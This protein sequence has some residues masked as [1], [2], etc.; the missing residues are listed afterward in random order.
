MQNKEDITYRRFAFPHIF[1]GWYIVA[2]GMGMHL[3]TSI[4]WVYGMQVF[5]TPIVQT[6]GWSRAIVSGAFGLQRIEGSILAPIEGFLVDRFGPRKMVLVGSF[7]TGLGLISLSFLSTIWMFYLSVLLVSLGTSASGTPRNWAIVQWFRRLRGRAL[8]IGA[9]GAVISGPLLFIVVWLVEGIGW[10]LAFLI[11]GFSTWF[12]LIPL[13][14]VFRSRPEEYGQLP[15]GDQPS[16]A[17]PKS[18]Y[19]LGHPRVDSPISRDPG[20]M[21][22]AQALKTPAFWILSVVFGAQTMG[23]SGMMVHLIPYLQTIGF[24]T[25]EA[26][27]VLAFYTVLSVFGRLGGGWI[28]DYV[29]PRFV[30]AGLL[31]CLVLGFIILAN[32]NAYWQVIPFALLYGTAFGGMIPARS[33]LVSNYFGTQNFGALQGL[34]RSVTVVAGV[35]SPVLLGLVFDWTESYV[36]AIYILTGVAAAAT[37]LA[38]LARPP[39]R[40]K[41][42]ASVI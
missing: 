35:V 40:D 28:M 22:I 31:G 18:T 25:S 19:V 29:D 21:T 10:R 23:V 1:Y 15:D 6:F 5:F 13:G 20:S 17:V 36:L 41:L 4:V 34:T 32:L 7:I 2:A 38:L 39:R 30:L 8:G 27:S 42:E 33:L 12:I 3:W 14:L 26:A 16:E 24:S 37:P 9:S 11:L